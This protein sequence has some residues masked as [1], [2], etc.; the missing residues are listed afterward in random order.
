MNAPN[1]RSN[2]KQTYTIW[3]ICFY[4]E[5]LLSSRQILP[6]LINFNMYFLW[7]ISTSWQKN[8]PAHSLGQ[9]TESGVMNKHFTRALMTLYYDP[10]KLCFHYN[11]GAPNQGHSPSCILSLYFGA[12]F[13]HRLAFRSS[14]PGKSLTL[15]LI[16]LF[17][18]YMLYKKI[19]LIG[20]WLDMAVQCVF[21][22]IPISVTL[23][24]LLPLVV[25][26]SW[27]AYLRLAEV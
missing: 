21:F 19:Q 25:P 18:L 1:K 15:V 24:I 13:F 3:T 27:G 23:L 26:K 17:M 5:K 6:T 11:Y 16:S 9:S 2:L 10:T 7:T 8:N 4:P 12:M 14:T 22:Y 20:Y